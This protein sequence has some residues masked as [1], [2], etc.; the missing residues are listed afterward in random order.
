MEKI[1][2]IGDSGHAKVI[3]DCIR[4]QGDNV[5]AKLDDRYK[6]KF[7]EGVIIKGPITLLEDLLTDEVKIVIAIGSNTIRK[8]IVERLDISKEKYAVIIH[9]QAIVCSSVKVGHGSVIMPGVVVNAGAI[10]GSHAIFNS[11]SVVEHDCVV[12]DFTHISP[13]AILTGNVKVGQGSHVGAGS[14]IIP[15][16]EVGS[17]TIVGAGSTVISNIES[18]VTAVGVPA[19]VIKREGL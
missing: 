4:S 8:S 7:Y 10:I 12:E 6:E 9:S 13:G 2:L 15:G 1:I 19:K 14:T 16:V 5:I 3:E 18:N 17:W 11:N